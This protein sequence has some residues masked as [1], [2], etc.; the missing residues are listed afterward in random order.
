MNDEAF[1][2]DALD[3]G[4]PDPLARREPCLR[5]RSRLGSSAVTLITLLALTACKGG[6]DDTSLPT[7]MPGGSGTLSS[8]FVKSFAPYEAAAASLR[9]TAARYLIQENTWH[10]S[11]APGTTYDSYPLASARVE[12]AHAVGLTGRGE[13]ISIVDSGFLRTH[14]VFAGKSIDVTGTVPTD[15]H[16]TAVASVAAGS[17][18]TMIGVAPGA[19]LAL[20]S[21]GSPADAAAATQRALQLGAVAQNNS[22]GY[23][24]PAD[25]ATFNSIFGAGSGANYLAALDAYAAKGVVVFAL[26]NDPATSQVEIMEGLPLLRPSLEAGWLA[27]GNAVPTFNNTRVTSAQM[28]SADCLQAARWCLVADG[29]WQA[30]TAASNSSYGFSIGSSFAAPQVAGA[31]AILAEAFPKLTPHQLRLRLLASADNSFF[32]HTNTLAI[33]S[34]FSHGYNSKYGH[35]FLD[36]RAALLPI[37]QTSMRMQDGTAHVV[38]Q[39]LVVSGAAIGDAVERSLG[40]IEVAVTDSLEGGFRMPAPVLSAG[41]APRPLADGLLVK[42]MTT[43]L[44]RSRAA[45]VKALSAPFDAFTGQTMDFASPDGGLSG[46]VLVPSPGSGAESFGL[47]MK[48]ALVEGPVRVDVGMKI[49]R[50]EGVLGL[51][52]ADAGLPASDL[53]ALRLGLSSEAADGGFFS[54]SGETGVADLGSP[55]YLSNVSSARFSSVDMT[56]GKR[57]VFTKGDRVS[58]GVSMPMAVTSG[59]AEMVLPVVRSS[60]ATAFEPV[61]LNL[62]PSDR[63]VDLSIGYQRPIGNGVEMLAEIVHAENYGN[64]AGVKDT[65]GVLAV[66]FSF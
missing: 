3:T 4:K 25:N 40:S 64:R 44:T 48:Q 27:V 5:N 38:P 13:T 54:I 31:L 65:A 53:V 10:Y 14:E 45:P 57:E 7:P 59:R 39:P 32:T 60:G 29:S 1:H 28:Q 17:S 63:Q 42:A 46:A 9:D 43:D 26:A 22:W 49:A 37:G 36:L 30:A 21:S 56:F 18:S 23:S 16:G 50:D 6:G 41:A 62:A 52:A 34:T 47:S 58:F 61:A 15:D 20:G 51:G 2:D 33:T 35:G 24:Q 8:Y 19:R 66:T 11:S 12:Y 55:A